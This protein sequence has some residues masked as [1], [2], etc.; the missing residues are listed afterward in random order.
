MRE[1]VHLQSCARIE[2]NGAQHVLRTTF[3]VDYYLHREVKPLTTPYQEVYG[4]QQTFVTSTTYFVWLSQNGGK[5]RTGKIIET[6][7]AFQKGPF[8]H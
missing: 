4:R 5:M 2:R 6:L 3:H 1:I 8:Y 7:T